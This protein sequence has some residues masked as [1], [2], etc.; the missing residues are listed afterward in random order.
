MGAEEKN[1][2]VASICGFI[3]AGMLLFGGIAYF[4]FQ[5]V[6]QIIVCFIGIALMMFALWAND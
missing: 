5:M 3:G 6:W 4:F 1:E 2:L